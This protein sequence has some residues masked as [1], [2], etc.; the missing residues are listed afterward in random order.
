MRPVEV[1]QE[2]ESMQSPVVKMLKNS[3]LVPTFTSLNGP[4]C[5]GVIKTCNKLEGLFGEQTS[6]PELLQELRTKEEDLALQSLGLA[7]SFLEDALI[8]EK[9][10]R[11][12]TFKRYTPETK[13]ALEYMVLDSQS[14]QHL[15]IVESAAGKKEG[16]LLHFVD[17]C[18]TPFGKRQLQR[19]LMAPLMNIEKL[20]DR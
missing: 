9:T 5:P 16:S 3:P 17:H 7:M 10:L 4:K 19:W 6:W 14:L 13:D 11:P 15:E 12:G 1:I 20:K 8:L 18:V 2:R